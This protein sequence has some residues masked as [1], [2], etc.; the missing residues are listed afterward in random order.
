MPF[1]AWIM[2]AITA[3]VLFGGIA[4]CLIKIKVKK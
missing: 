2:L 1:S 3:L 4:V